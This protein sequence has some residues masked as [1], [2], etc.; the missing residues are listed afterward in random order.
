MRRFE[1]TASV[2]LGTAAG[3]W[4]D[5]WVAEGFGARLIGLALLP[6]LPAGRALLL[7]RCGSLH[8]A[9]MRFPIDV[10]FVSWPPAP[11]CWVLGIEEA[12]PP[13]RLV[14]ARRPAHR[15]IAA[16]E[17]NAHTLNALGARPGTRL[18]ISAPLARV[19]RSSE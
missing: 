8:T 5:A 3:P 16:L 17:A 15:R 4:V 2:R 19:L 18:S 7:P 9:G 12:V 10:A 13:W 6:R 11:E 14:R 1:S